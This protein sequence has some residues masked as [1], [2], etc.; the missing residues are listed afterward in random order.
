M[1]C[2]T[3]ISEIRPLASSLQEVVESLLAGVVDPDP[4]YPY[5]DGQVEVD[6]PGFPGL[7]ETARVEQALDHLDQRYMEVCRTDA[8]A[9]LF[10]PSLLHPEHKRIKGYIGCDM[11]EDAC[12]LFLRH[13][14]DTDFRCKVYQVRN[15]WNLQPSS[16]GRVKAR[17]GCTDP[18]QFPQ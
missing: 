16:L 12:S 14:I 8:F 6:R 15:E 18:Y 4:N 1:L 13:P 9:H 7:L 10:T 11:R 3:D 17:L 5:P 2:K